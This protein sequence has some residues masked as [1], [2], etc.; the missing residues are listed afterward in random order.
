MLAPSLPP[1]VPAA[2]ELGALAELRG[3][4]LAW[5][6]CSGRTLAFR[7]DSPGPWAVLVSEVMAQQTQVARV[8]ERW[9]EFMATF[10]TPA[11][12]AGATPAEAIRA[13][14]G[15]GYNR[16]VLDL[17]RAA[18]AIVAGGG[19]VPDT[20][21]GLLALPGVGA[22]TARAVAA[23]AFGQ[24]VGAV[25]VNVRRVVGR[26]VA[27][28]PA[29]LRPRPLQDAA[30][31]LVA[32]GRAADWTHAVMDLGALVCR[33]ARPACGDCPARPWCAYAGA[34][35]QAGSGGP[36]AQGP[37]AGPGAPA[38][39]P[40]PGARAAP[41]ARERPARFETTTR[42]LRG[43]IVERLCGAEPGAWVEVEAP[44]GGHAAEA[45][46]AALDGLARDGLAEV[47]SGRRARLP[48]SAP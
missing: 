48:G 36:G 18:A 29:A 32:P 13:W 17:R 7:A 8:D 25:D 24:P 11:A 15:L 4:V 34:G 16:R 10:P 38:A 40:G 47:A 44:L 31:A 23:I 9:R 27:G 12:L 19:A 39:G 45:V 28:D 37:G 30:D 3:A 20:L 26:I 41:A 21:D 43:R 5:F 42:W 46:D 2:L 6:D 35:A 1:S 14:R 33:P 22:Y